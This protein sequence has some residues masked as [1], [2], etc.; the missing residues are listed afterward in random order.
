MSQTGLIDAI[1]ESAKISKGRLKN[2]TTP[3]TEVLH[4]DKDGLKCQDS[5]NYPSFIGKL[6]YLAQI[7]QIYI[8][9]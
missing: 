1:T 6:N 3:A 5:W 9:P 8:S 4:A 7:D 2:K